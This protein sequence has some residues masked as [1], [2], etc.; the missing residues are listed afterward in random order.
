MHNVHVAASFKEFRLGPCRSSSP[1]VLQVRECRVVLL[2]GLSLI[3]VPLTLMCFF[4]DDHSLGARS[5][6]HSE[7]VERWQD[8]ESAV[9]EKL[10]DGRE[11]HH[12]GTGG[13][14]HTAKAHAAPQQ[15]QLTA[16][17]ADAQSHGS[18]AGGAGNAAEQ[19]DPVP[20]AVETGASHRSAGRTGSHPR[21]AQQRSCCSCCP[22]AQH[23]LMI[24]ILI[25]ISDFIGSL[26]AG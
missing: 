5:T 24:P 20:K 3:V 16:T 7:Q 10:L 17:A 1:T 12:T 6:A 8:A 21:K 4:S 26:A 23:S 14:G 2:A 9:R 19:H 11:Q 13:G 25:S 15:Q 18:R 22:G